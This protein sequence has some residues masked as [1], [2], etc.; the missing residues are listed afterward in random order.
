MVVIARLANPNS[1]ACAA[2]A[3]QLA[4]NRFMAMAKFAL[5]MHLLNR[6]VKNIAAVASNFHATE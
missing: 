3:L 1:K 6:K 2:V 4:G 5:D